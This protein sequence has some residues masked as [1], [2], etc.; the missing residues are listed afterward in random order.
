MRHKNRREHS[1]GGFWWI[2]RG[3]PEKRPVRVAV[4]TNVVASCLCKKREGRV[5]RSIKN[6]GLIRLVCRGYL[7]L[8]NRRRRRRDGLIMNDLHVSADILNRNLLATI[9][10]KP[11]QQF[12]SSVVRRGDI[13]RIAL[14]SPRDRPSDMVV[15]LTRRVE[16][17]GAIRSRTL[18]ATHK[19]S[20]VEMLSCMALSTVKS[21]L[22]TL[23]PSTT[24]A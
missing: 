10:N 1:E 22:C 8:Y 24:L 17:L 6:R 12:S 3:R 18:A 20:V 15:L 19:R 16:P 5:M 13:P 2:Y 23:A 11:G 7:V 14:F 9:K 4:T 21:F